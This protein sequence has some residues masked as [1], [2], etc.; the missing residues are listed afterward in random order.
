[1]PIFSNMFYAG[2]REAVHHAI[3][4]RN[5]GFTHFS[6][7]RD[8]AGAENFFVPEEAPML[9]TKLRSELGIEVFCHMG[10]KYCKS[11]DS[12]VIVNECGHATEDMEDVAGSQFRKAVDDGEFFKFA[13]RDM[14]QY[15]FQNVKNIVER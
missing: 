15:V 1:M 14:Q 7:G 5:M 13:D 11:C 9:M 10:A 6:V 8:H 4:R 3:I 12:F 2:P